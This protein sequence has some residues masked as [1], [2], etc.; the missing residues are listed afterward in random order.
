MK[1]GTNQQ[2]ASQRS[3]NDRSSIT[4]VGYPSQ[5]MSSILCANSS[6]RPRQM[7]WPRYSIQL[8]KN[9]L[10]QIQGHASNLYYGQY[11]LI[12]IDVLV[13]RTQKVWGCHLNREGQNATLLSSIGRVLR[14]ETSQVASQF[15]GPARTTKKT[16]MGCKG[17]FIPI[18]FSYLHLPVSTIGV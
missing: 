16:M 13:W 10:F 12:V 1:L 3:R 7:T 17:K 8:V 15:E 2:K 11:L 6:G 14:V 18:F 9:S 5:Y 4:T